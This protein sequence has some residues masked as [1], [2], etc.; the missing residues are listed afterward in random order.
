MAETPRS[1]SS[2][3]KLPDLQAAAS[4]S[5]GREGEKA[6]MP[7]TPG[8][9]ELHAPALGILGKVYKAARSGKWKCAPPSPAICDSAVED[10]VRSSPKS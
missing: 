3:C 1:A 2:T 6:F 9:Q 4:A 5:S 8:H 10:T 7:E